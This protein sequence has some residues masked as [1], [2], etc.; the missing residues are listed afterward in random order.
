MNKLKLYYSVQN[1]GDGS[2]YPRLFESLK[3][4][5]WDQEH[6]YEGWG[7]NCTGSFELESESPITCLDKIKT[8]EEVLAD[9]CMEDSS[10]LKEFLKEFFP[11]GLNGKFTV[12]EKKI[13]KFYCY[14]IYFNDKYLLDTFYMD[15]FYFKPAKEIEDKLNNL[16][17]EI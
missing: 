10:D 17:N 5:D 15:T 1:G 8:K 9:L 3:L 13:E 7:E 14:E 16:F 2:A 6:M 11:N 12:K 4:A